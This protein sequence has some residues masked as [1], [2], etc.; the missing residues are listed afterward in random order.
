[1]QKRNRHVGRALNQTTASEDQ[2]HVRDGLVAA[3]PNAHMPTRVRLSQAGQSRREGLRQNSLFISGSETTGCLNICK[4]L[5]HV[6]NFPGIT[7]H[8]KKHGNKTA[9]GLYRVYDGV[10]YGSWKQVPLVQ[11]KATRAHRCQTRPQALGSVD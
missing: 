8:P 10:R 4:D 6:R 7:L 11:G 9:R 2:L 1:M 3:P 5:L